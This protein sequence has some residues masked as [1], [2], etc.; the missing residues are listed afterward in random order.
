M[1][2]LLFLVN[3]GFRA[4]TETIHK[5]HLKRQVKIRWFDEF[6]NFGVN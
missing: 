1:A 5:G 4:V 3:P 6:R 2:S